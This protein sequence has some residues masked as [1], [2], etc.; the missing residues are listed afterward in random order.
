[1]RA[2]RDTGWSSCLSLELISP[3]FRNLDSVLSLEKVN[4]RESRIQGEMTAVI[5]NKILMEKGERLNHV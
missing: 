4:S 5:R 2:Q 1:V 3:C